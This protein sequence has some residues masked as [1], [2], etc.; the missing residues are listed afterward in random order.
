MKLYNSGFN[1][2]YFIQTHTHT[3]SFTKLKKRLLAYL[4]EFLKL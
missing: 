1:Y 2:L 4:I 3:H